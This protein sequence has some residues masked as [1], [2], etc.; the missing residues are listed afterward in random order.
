MIEGIVKVFLR[1]EI[2]IVINAA[3]AAD[4]DAIVEFIA[5]LGE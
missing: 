5:D 2:I 3:S 4:N 1:D